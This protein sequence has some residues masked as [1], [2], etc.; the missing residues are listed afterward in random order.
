LVRVVRRG[1]CGVNVGGWHVREAGAQ[2]DNAS[3]HRAC[4]S[5]ARPRVAA[6]SPMSGASWW[7]WRRRARTRNGSSGCLAPFAARRSRDWSSN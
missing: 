2:T 6:R 4:S 5:D 7:A 1:R 3:A